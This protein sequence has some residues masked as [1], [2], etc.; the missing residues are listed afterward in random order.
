[1]RAVLVTGVST[2]IGRAI[3]EELLESDFI[4]IGSV[5][6]ESD[7]KYFHEKYKLIMQLEMVRIEGVEP[8]RLAA[9]DPKSSVSTNST[10]SALILF[11][12]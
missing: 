5:R 4:V 11:H 10:I 6:K 2:G 12:F 8:T 7:A 9:L 1:M 3:A